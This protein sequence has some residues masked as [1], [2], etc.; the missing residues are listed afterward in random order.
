[1]YQCQAACAW[2]AL[3]LATLNFYITQ[4]L[5]SIV[6]VLVVAKVVEPVWG[7]KGFLLF[8]AVVN[9]WT[10]FCTFVLLYLLYTVDRTG[11][12]L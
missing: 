3:F 1:M 8:A 7:S 2:P 6:G 5:L 9:F 4:L 11:D 10:G 12:L